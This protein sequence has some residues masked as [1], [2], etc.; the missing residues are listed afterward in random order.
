MDKPL[1][2]A[3]VILAYAT[4]AAAYADCP[5]PRCTDKR[6][7]ILLGT[8]PGTVADGL[9]R[10]LAAVWKTQMGTDFI[11]VNNKPGR[12]GLLAAE[13][14]AKSAPDGGTVLLA[15][16]SLNT[17]SALNS[18]LNFNPEKDLVP[19]AQVASMPYA[20]AVSPGLGVGSVAEL[21]SKAK[22]DPGKVSYGSPGSGSMENIFSELFNSS[23]H[24]KTTHVPF[25]GSAPALQNAMAGQIGYVITSPSA[26][27][28]SA[29]QDKIKVIATTGSQRSRLLPQTPT[30]AE[31]G[32]GK[33]TVENRF[34]LY[35]P[36]GTKPDDVRKWNAAVA[37]AL[38]SPQFSNAALQMGAT[39]D[40]P[41]ADGLRQAL[42]GETA[43][44][45]QVVR[46]AKMKIE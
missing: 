12:Q 40:S 20:I 27:E 23:N 43:R 5:P 7:E 26:V 35:L 36:A 17:A 30:L 44:W 18:R 32:M 45:A 22:K 38:K 16:S 14:V 33:L 9:A 3:V 34:V 10:H 1:R 2:I 11:I 41:T 19:A 29:K 31:L 15:T 39:I 46:S 24:I 42:S 4:A 13:A 28:A 6:I 8:T 37:Q 25:K 21:L